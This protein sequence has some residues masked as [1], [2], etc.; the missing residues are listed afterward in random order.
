MRRES[1]KTGGLDEAV[2]I[3]DAKWTEKVNL[4]T[5]KCGGCNYVFDHRADRW[6]VICKQ[7]GR[8]TNINWVREKY[9]K[10]I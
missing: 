6:N 4:L 8:I 9:A 3:I 10:G 5:I 1:E 2:R 7:C